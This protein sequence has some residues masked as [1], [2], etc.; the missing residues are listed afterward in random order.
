MTQAIGRAVRYGQE[1][2]VHIYHMLSMNTADVTIFQARN[3]G[4]VVYRD[5]KA[6]IVGKEHLHQCPTSISVLKGP[7]LD[8]G[9][10]DGLGTRVAGSTRGYGEEDEKAINELVE[11]R[12]EE[13]VTTAAEAAVGH[14]DEDSR[15]KSLPDWECEIEHG[16]MMDCMPGNENQKLEPDEQ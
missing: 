15:D 6:F 9:L 5:S 3:R 16:D 11:G 1:K 13:V 4:S 14:T 7:G 2:H 8:F 10:G 12:T